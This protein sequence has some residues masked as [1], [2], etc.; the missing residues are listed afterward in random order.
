MRNIFF[1]VAAV[2]KDPTNQPPTF[3]LKA[4]VVSS[5]SI[6]ARKISD[7]VAHAF[8]NSKINITMICFTCFTIRALTSYI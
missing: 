5:L 7:R 6:L 8:A 2:S 1:T 4:L 3:R